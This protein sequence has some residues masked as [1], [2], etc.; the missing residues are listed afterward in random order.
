MCNQTVG[1]AAAAIERLGI[2]TVCIQ[3]LREV[4]RRVGPPRS[5][6]V[7]FRHGFP[8]GN[9]DDPEMQRRVIRA[10]LAMID[11]PHVS[12][13]T[14]RDFVLPDGPSVH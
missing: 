11:D 6:F 4:A 2:P 9:A 8:L 14:L 5:L 1:L 13:G 12:A 10:A 7:P 3:L